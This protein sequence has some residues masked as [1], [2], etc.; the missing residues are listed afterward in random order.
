MRFI[1]FYLDLSKAGAGVSILFPMMNPDTPTTYAKFLDLVDRQHLMNLSHDKY[2]RFGQTY[3]NLLW[4]MRPEVADKIRATALDPFYKD[5]V[6][7]VIHDY[8][9]PL[10]DEPAL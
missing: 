7:Q 3:F 10:Y 2:H 1:F 6:A 9:R 4:E 5:H 8:V